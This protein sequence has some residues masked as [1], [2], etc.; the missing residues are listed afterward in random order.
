L[1]FKNTY[2]K[3]RPPSIILILKANLGFIKEDCYYNL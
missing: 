3:N 1:I 2:F